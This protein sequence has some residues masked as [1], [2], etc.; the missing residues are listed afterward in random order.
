MPSDFPPSGPWTGYYLYQHSGQK[1]GM[2]LIL[3][4]AA[5]GAIEGEGMDDVAPFV[6]SGR[7]E[8]AA[9]HAN[10]T[11]TYLGMHKVEYAGI[12]CRRSICGDWTLPGLTGGFWIRPDSVQEE[13]WA[14]ETEET[15]KP[16]HAKSV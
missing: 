1:H 13:L 15:E 6:I 5:D 4:F 9:S 2:R 12:Y 7:F 3:T 11:K 10:W 14:V 16:L 8:K